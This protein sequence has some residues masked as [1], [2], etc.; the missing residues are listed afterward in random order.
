MI[1]RRREPRS[2]ADLHVVLWGMD[3]HGDRFVQHAH[4]HEISLSGALLSELN[5]ELRSG[6]LVG[7][8]YEGKQAR[9]RVVWTRRSGN[10][11]KVDAA[12][13]RVE[14]DSCPWEDRVSREQ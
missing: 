12:I 8:L 1:E 4:A 2:K 10:N 5:V 7:V 13:H 9:F 14:G 3:T 6:D 11:S